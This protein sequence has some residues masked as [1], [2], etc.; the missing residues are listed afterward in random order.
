MTKRT[1]PRTA[2]LVHLAEDLKAAIEAGDLEA[3]RVAHEAIGRLLGS[4]AAK[5][6][7]VVDLATARA[8][9]D[10]SDHP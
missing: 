8:R 3:A 4:T 10:G 2:L 9:R 6:A 1:S 5:N 7:T